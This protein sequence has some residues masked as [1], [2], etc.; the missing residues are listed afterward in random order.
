MLAFMRKSYLNLQKSCNLLKITAK[1]VST[2][3]CLSTIETRLNTSNTD[4]RF[5]LNNNSKLTPEQQKF[6]E[7]NGY[8]VVKNLV[9]KNDIKRY[10]NRF[11]DIA[12]RKVSTPP[13][14]TVQKEV[15]VA[16]E[17]QNENTV[18]K[19]QELFCDEVLFEYCKHPDILNYV[20][21]FIGPNLMA[22][23]TMLINKPPDKGTKSSRHPLHQDLHYFPIRPADKIIGAWT[24]METINRENGC[25]VAI[26]GSHRGQHLEHGYP[27]WE[28]GVNKMYYGIKEMTGSEN[29]VHLEMECGDCVLFHPLLIHGSGMNRTKGY[30][31]AISCHFAASDC[32]YIEVK[33][34][35]QEN[36]AN[37]IIDVAK[38][39]FGATF[40]DYSLIWKFRAQLVRGQQI[41]L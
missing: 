34:T 28:G 21:A 3:R 23:H 18:Y 20:E 5:S 24:A 14:L 10:L 37:E 12:N 29:R 7:E 19:L 15:S 22:I 17:Q 9:P 39:R 36:L 13:G 35:I 16:K 30:R 38:K 32:H 40:T 26:P 33:G 1:T 4:Y 25:L 27:D 2:T 11:K 31:K 8:I 6:Y 41:N